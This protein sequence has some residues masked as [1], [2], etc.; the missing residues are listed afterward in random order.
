MFGTLSF[1][2]FLPPPSF[3]E[4]VYK[5]FD[6]HLEIAPKGRV[7]ARSSVLDEDEESDDKSEVRARFL[8]SRIL[9]KLT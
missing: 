9:R 1:N 5:L 4:L 3:P 7:K 6:A 8:H 2:L